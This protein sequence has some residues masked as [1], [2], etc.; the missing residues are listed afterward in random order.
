MLFE[1]Q[2]NPD[3]INGMRDDNFTRSQSDV[4][5]ITEPEFQL[6]VTIS[7]FNLNGLSEM[8]LNAIDYC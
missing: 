3:A 6:R 5:V 2:F 1:G 4:L 8:Y 7:A